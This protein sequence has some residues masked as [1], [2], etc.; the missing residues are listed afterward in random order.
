MTSGRIGTGNLLAFAIFFLPISA[1]LAS[2]E[3]T[4]ADAVL[5][6]PDLTSNGSNQGGAAGTP[7]TLNGNRG[8]FADSTGRL[9]VADT[10]N[11][12][13]LMFSSAATFA[14]DAPADLVI[15]QADFTGIQENRGGANPAQNSLAGPRS[16]CVD[17]AGHLYVA[18]SGNI[19]ILR[20]DP[21]FTNGMLA[22]Q[23]FGQAGS[24]TTKTQANAATADASN[25]G[26]P[27]GIAVDEFGNL[28]LADLFLKRVL[29]YNTPANGGD[30]IADTVIGQANF[31]GSNANQGNANPAANTLFNPEGV[32]IDTQG[33]LW[34][35]DQENH[36]VLLF[37]R[38]FS[39]NMNASHVFGQPNFTTGT[40][41]NPPTNASLNVPV[42]VALDPKSGNLFVADS[43]NFRVLEVA[44]PRNATTA[45]RVFGQLGSF[46]TK[47]LNN[48]GL[49]ANSLNDPGGVACDASGNLFVGDRNNNRAL[50]FNVA[51]PASG[52]GGDNGG[53]DNGGTGG[54]NGTPTTM[55]GTCGN[56]AAAMMPLALLVLIADRHRIR[57]GRRRR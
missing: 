44:D 35:A 24:F 46:T 56:G 21:P 40:A 12:R 32:A 43:V 8:L 27:D 19:R 48:G 39:T 42:Q 15:G 1:A 36:R 4:T 29:I 14:N 16:V 23:V 22:A 2:P 10:G 3:D 49:S 13:V 34:V 55:C 52:G 5:G 41:A 28:F 6:Q 45:S 9:W 26:N 25:M 18:D 53:T 38:P 50:R 54:T 17:L 11:N 57:R 51:P 20:F 47:T 30:T 31:N 37:V 33:D 7:S